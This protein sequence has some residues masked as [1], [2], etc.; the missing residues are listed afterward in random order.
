MSG[1]NTSLGI[2]SVA[3]TIAALGAN[4]TQTVTT[5]TGAHVT[6]LEAAA[7]EFGAIL[8][9][10]PA[11]A[12]P[13]TRNA[14]V[15]Q[16]TDADGNTSM[17][18]LNDLA[19]EIRSHTGYD[20]L[21]EFSAGF[22]NTSDGYSVA[23]INHI[24]N[25]IENR[26]SSMSFTQLTQVIG[27][28]ELV[29][30]DNLGTQAQNALTQL[31]AALHVSLG[32][33]GLALDSSP[34]G[35]SLD[36]EIIVSP[37]AREVNA[38]ALEQLP[39][40]N[41]ELIADQVDVMNAQAALAAAQ[42]GFSPENQAAVSAAQAALAAAQALTVV[43]A[44]G[45]ANEA[46]VTTAQANLAAA[47]QALAA[48]RAAAVGAL[49]PRAF[50]EGL[51]A[52]LQSIN[53]CLS[54]NG[55]SGSIES[56]CTGSYVRDHFLMSANGLFQGTNE[57]WNG[58]GNYWSEITF[59]ND[60]SGE[61]NLSWS[62]YHQQFPQATFQDYRWGVNNQSA[63]YAQVTPGGSGVP[64][65]NGLIQ[66]CGLDPT[67]PSD[68]LQFN[69]YLDAVM[70][71]ASTKACFT[72]GELL[73][74]KNLVA[75]NIPLASQSSSAFNAITTASQNVAQA[76]GALN[77][78][79]SQL[80]SAQALAIQN[81]NVVYQA[82][83]TKAQ[84][85]Q[86]ALIA[87]AQATL[88][89]AV[90]QFNLDQNALTS[91]MSA[92]IAN[93]SS[94]ARS[95]NT[96]INQINASI[97]SNRNTVV[98]LNTQKLVAESRS[99]TA[100]EL[101]DDLNDA[102]AALNASPSN[103]ALQANVAK[104]KKALETFLGSTFG[105]NTAALAACDQYIQ[106]QA[107]QIGNLTQQL[108]AAN[109]LL[110][111]NQ[112]Q[113]LNL[114]TRLLNIPNESF[115]G[116]LASIENSTGVDLSQ[117]FSEILQDGPLTL[118]KLN[119]IYRY[120]NQNLP[121]GEQFPLISNSQ[122][123]QAASSQISDLLS[124]AGFLQALA[125]NPGG[126]NPDM[127]VFRLPGSDMPVS[128]NAALN[129]IAAGS[130]V[131]VAQ[132]MSAILDGR[133]LTQRVVNEINIY[134]SNPPSGGA[135]FT[136]M[137]A[138][139]IDPT[140]GESVSITGVQ[141]AK[142]NFASQ[143]NQINLG[144]LANA[145]SPI[146]ADAA[147]FVLRNADGST[148]NV[149]LN[150][151]IQSYAE[152]GYDFS[153]ILPP[154]TNS[155]SVADLSQAVG[156]LNA[157]QTS[158]VF[159]V[160]NRAILNEGLLR[161][162]GYAKSSNA[163]SPESIQSAVSLLRALGV[164]N[165]ERTYIQAIL[166]SQLESFGTHNTF[167]IMAESGG[168][169]LATSPLGDP[170]STL[171]FLSLARLADQAG[172]DLNAIASGIF[173][174][175]NDHKPIA[176][177]N[178]ASLNTLINQLNIANV[179]TPFVI[180]NPFASSPDIATTNISGQVGFGSFATNSANSSFSANL[181]NNFVAIDLSLI[182]AM[183]VDAGASFTRVSANLNSFS[184]EPH[185]RAVLSDLGQ[186]LA[187]LTVADLDSAG[188][189]SITRETFQF[190]SVAQSL[191][192]RSDALV[193]FEQILQYESRLRGVDI[194]SAIPNLVNADGN[195]SLGNLSDFGELINQAVPGANIPS[196]MNIIVRSAQNQIETLS[197]SA[198]RQLQIANNLIG[199]I[200]S[201]TSSWVGNSTETINHMFHTKQ[202]IPSWWSIPQSIFTELAV[203]GVAAGRESTD[204][205][206]C[207]NYPTTSLAGLLG[208]PRVP[209]V[210]PALLTTDHINAQYRLV[211]DALHDLVPDFVP[212]ALARDW[213]AETFSSLLALLP[214][215]VENFS[216]QIASLSAQEDGLSVDSIT[217]TSPGHYQNQLLVIEGL[218][219]NAPTDGGTPVDFIN[220]ISSQL[221]LQE[222]DG[223]P[224]QNT[225][226]FE[227]LLESLS[228]LLPG[229][230]L[231]E[232]AA[233]W[234]AQTG[235]DLLAMLEVQTDTLES[236]LIPLSVVQSGVGSM[237]LDLTSAKTNLQNIQFMDVEAA[238]E[239]GQASAEVAASARAFSPAAPSILSA[240]EMNSQ[241][242]D[243][244][245]YVNAQGQFFLNRQPT[246]ARD[247]S[248]AAM[249]ISGA[250]QDEKLND[251]MNKINLN[252]T[253]IL[254]AN[255]LSAATSV[256]DLQTRIAAQREQYG[257]A[258]ILGEITAG[259]M[260]DGDIV[261]GTDISSATSTFQSTLKTAI[262]N[263]TN[264]QDLDTQRLQ[265]LTSEI[266][267]NR[268]AMTQLIQAFE[269]ML[270][271]L[272][273]NLR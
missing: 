257:F 144:A 42:A 76:Q 81:A 252:N 243:G 250:R 101:R 167:K 199:S 137:T 48:A 206:Y 96:Q 241:L 184:V 2:N 28:Q 183:A 219:E 187:Q 177:L 19:D 170:P 149:S 59:Y 70:P 237:S 57:T 123:I 40:L 91:L 61:G 49:P 92:A 160:S 195:I 203:V 64:A 55:G 161:V 46:A 3:S 259:A 213:T 157:D 13:L 246:N 11:D 124:Q 271:G 194:R 104:A 65:F 154:G 233:S 8:S 84:N 89:T 114:Q 193:S 169:L 21:M 34:G 140:S 66:A 227:A 168:R 23:D 223:T 172:L 93:D 75:T 78:A 263:A 150:Q 71:G 138:T 139:G 25:Q 100:S 122:L 87:Q 166:A 215:S 234:T 120:L 210:P 111:G 224:A 162:E 4:G 80:S 147:I 226:A 5:N 102:I 272:A 88:N 119:Q 113:L 265:Q 153:S 31:Q 132:T 209:L 142:F 98:S 171:T 109:A 95:I 222:Q 106:S 129:A 116:L 103:I 90:T 238:V 133:S 53:S 185:V 85:D 94:G 128:F 67:L 44:A 39:E 221:G 190:P 121:G 255:Y 258:D 235:R 54:A 97:N 130:G 207:G 134:C 62:Q 22:G 108:S 249:V 68:V 204:G 239:A 230:P 200:G 196:T 229:Y 211:T 165:P 266:Q 1:I 117:A 58:N 37:V 269:Q 26:Y 151:I 191:G 181:N 216:N 175:D 79:R 29:V 110:Q 247:A 86:A 143:L 176:V 152:K 16:V 10:Y 9:S 205:Q 188:N 69:S 15:F 52:G 14:A 186:A 36:Q 261:A 72:L 217:N 225:V 256:A 189:L 254:M 127:A 136:P 126:I 192:K 148:E 112:N 251:M 244:D 38:R 163:Q 201:P 240:A 30:S 232:N 273:Q 268:T 33:M 202:N 146:S 17:V 12:P 178:G 118:G 262:N 174:A 231:P 60:L 43:N 135:V 32:S 6:G 182:P 264:N 267:A 107:T 141:A 125:N 45:Q 220:A 208:I 105:T 180:N 56:Y 18:S 82:A 253:K 24:L 260:S 218:L 197:N 47:Q 236:V 131:N 115:S 159:R 245:L 164:Q 228:E 270:K 145:G 83:L 248:V 242:E 158:P 41:Q 20:P 35:V 179:G 156:R 74:L 214:N 51:S 173:Q 99:A 7:Y 50:L 63:L 155:F 212:P 73:E 27:N 198:A 77:L